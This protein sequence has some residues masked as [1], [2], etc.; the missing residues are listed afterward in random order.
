MRSLLAGVLLMGLGGVSASGVVIDYDG[1]GSPGGVTPEGFSF[2]VFGGTS[3]SSDGDV[4]TLTTGPSRGIWFG[5]ANHASGFSV[6]WQVGSSSEGNYLRVR[7]KLGEGATEWSLYL[8]DK[9]FYVGFG[10]D[11]DVL[12][13]G[14]A[15]GGGSMAWDPTEWHV[16]EFLMKDGVVT[17]RVDESRVLYHGPAVA[18]SVP[19]GFMVMGDGSGSTPTGT[20]SMLFDEVLYMTSPDF[21]IVPEPAGVAVLGLGLLGLR[22]RGGGRV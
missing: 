9:D 22:R 10:L 11:A 20:G 15:G 8:Y 21:E 14:T 2:V 12:S 19:T 17:Y 4:L 1:S 16:Y 5:N 13:W 7:A 6:P 18:S 3:W